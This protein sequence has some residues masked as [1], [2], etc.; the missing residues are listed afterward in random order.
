[1][2]RDPPPPLRPLHARLQRA[3]AREGQDH[4]RA[5][6]LILDLEDAVAPDAK[7]A[8]ASGSAPPR[9]RRASTA[10]EV[11][12]RVNGLD[13]QWHA[14]R[15]RRRRRRPA[16]PPSWYPR[17]TRSA[18]V[19]PRRRA[20]EAGGRARPHQDLG[21]GRDAGGDAARRGDRRRVGAPGCSSWAP[22]TW[23]RSCTPTH[24]PGR[25]PLLTGLGLCLNWPPGRRQGDPRRRLQRREGPRGLRW[26][27]APGRRDGLRRQDAH[28]PGPGRAA[29]PRRPV[30]RRPFIRSRWRGSAWGCIPPS[31]PGSSGMP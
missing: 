15:P 25:Q 26:P 31:T 3:G 2:S 10:P 7:A 12:I 22:T 13:T 8:P 23:P 6:A 19:A 9:P 24:V 16:R 4:R 30:R 28:P 5:D 11:T 1:M 29:I 27:S 14:G 18:D 17:S 21:D 20:M